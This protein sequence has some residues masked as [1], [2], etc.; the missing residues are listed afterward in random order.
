MSDGEFAGRIALIT[1]SLRHALRSG[2]RKESSDG[3]DYSLSVF[4]SN[5]GQLLLR[6]P[7]NLDR[8]AHMLEPL[9]ISLI[10][11]SNAAVS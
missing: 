1:G 6:R 8:A 7:Q 4:G 11:R 5:L 2:I 3:L 9:F 10:A